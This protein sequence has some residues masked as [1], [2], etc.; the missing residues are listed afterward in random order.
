VLA[1]R[2]KNSAT[3]AAVLELGSTNLLGKVKAR[4]P[5]SRNGVAKAHRCAEDV[6]RLKDKFERIWEASFL[7][8]TVESSSAASVRSFL[9][10]DA[11]GF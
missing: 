9:V 11:L 5:K 10:V 4:P 8:D 1:W 3:R 2:G 6:L 7:N